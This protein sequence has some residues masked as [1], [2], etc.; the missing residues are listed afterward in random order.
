VRPPTIDSVLWSLQER[1]KELNCLYRVDEILGARELPADEVLSAVVEA[2]PSGWQYPASCQAELVLRGQVHRSPGFEQSAFTQTAPVLLQGEPVGTLTVSYRAALPAADE[3]PFLKEERRLIDA[4]ANRIGQFVL[5]RE[6]APVFGS[7]T[8]E[9]EEARAEGGVSVVVELLRRTDRS[10]FRR[11]A[12]KMLNLL[13]VHGVAEA[14]AILRALSAE[15]AEEAPDDNRPRAPG[16]V[17]DTEA[18]A[19]EAFA[20][21]GRHLP[22]A[23]VLSSLQSWIKED[24]VA[25]LVNTMESPYSSLVEIGGALERY[26]LTGVDAR[27]LPHPTQV[28]LKVALIRRLLSE[29]PDFV[30]A[31]RRFAEIDDFVELLQRTVLLPKSHG[32]LGGKGS[33]LFLAAQVLRRSPEAR[34]LLGGIRV[35]RTWYVPSDGIIQ[36]VAL[37]NL[38]DVYSWRF[39][40]LGQVREEYPHLQEVFRSSRFPAEIVNGLAAALDDLGDRPL[41]VRSSSLLEDREGAAFSGKYRSLF[42]ANVGGKAERL[43]ALLGAVAEVYASVFGPD[44]IQY[45]AER[46]LLE[47]HEEMGI[48]IQ[49]VV[50]RRL[51]R[52]FLPAFSG[53][54][55]SR[56]EFRWSPRIQRADGLLRLVPGLGTRAVDRVADDYPV[57]VAPG[58]PG[59]RVNASPEEVL[60]YSPKRVDL[61]DL[62]TGR[63]ETVPV[64]RLLE[65]ARGD[66]ADLRLLLS[67]L[68]GGRLRPPSPLE[69]SLDPRRTVFTFEGLFSQ[70]SFLA[71]MRAIL[72]LLEESLGGP[73][74][75]EFA[76][77]GDDLYLLQ[78]R[79]QSHSPDAL[80]VAIPRDVPPGQILFTARRHVSSGAVPDL[81]HV[82]YVD[83][84]AYGELPTPDEMR[85]VGRAVGALNALLPRRRFILMGPGRWGSR[86]D[87]RLGVSVTYADICHAAVLVEIARKRG[88]Y[89][90]EVS[91]GTHFFQDLVESAIRYLPL[92]PDDPGVV[93][94]ELF[95]RR[96]R[97]L[98]PELLPAFARLAPVVRVIDVGRA[99]EGKVLRVLLNGELDEAL[100]C[101]ADPAA[102][103]APRFV[104]PGASAAGDEHWRWRLR[105]ARRL[106][107]EAGRL[108]LGVKAVYLTGSTK[109]ATAGPGSDLDLIVH[110]DEDPARRARLEAWLQGWSLCLAEINYLRTGYA[111]AGLLDAHLVTDEDFARGT[112]HTARIAAVTDPARP[113]PLSPEA[114]PEGPA[115]R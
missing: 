73:V 115:A 61:I 85:E 63:F 18:L 53:V 21:A 23:E 67:I 57:L 83:P 24:R 15:T 17:R 79:P 71:R 69:G 12:R 84:E 104:A 26:R 82:V 96:E 101:F 9:K 28:G 60:R 22:E 16:T 3:G 102:G 14:K 31:C 51:G 88:G 5:H 95:L 99:T 1:A 47:R 37:N 35:P 30:S 38:D 49:E 36:F 78:C 81:T 97:N 72:R 4:L 11:L 70:T 100:A 89:V 45:R 42:L 109:N 6:L 54:G 41:I 113:L 86:G 43:A 74:D 105:M 98:L 10:L 59:L 34:D 75:I 7:R 48:L 39:R 80:P 33:G 8:A 68:E 13:S 77:D 92:Y 2:I 65:E 20:V 29:A 62:E 90:P 110:C 44:P 50:G 46:G 93:F 56:N 55:F 25:F 87:I 91:F 111:S 112:S 66:P 106:A 32:R 52:Y 103:A 64:G 19:L 108:D 27:E 107:A 114:E 58:Q 76:A 94:D 40:D